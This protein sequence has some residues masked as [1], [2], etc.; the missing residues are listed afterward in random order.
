MRCWRAKGLFSAY[1]DNE[2]R[3]RELDAF[4]AHLDGCP[5]CRRELAELRVLKEAVGSVSYRLPAGFHEAVH[6]HSRLADLV[7]ERFRSRS[8][9][10]SARP[11]MRLVLVAASVVII[12]VGVGLL[13]LNN[14]TG[15]PSLKILDLPTVGDRVTE[16]SPTPAA[17]LEGERGEVAEA[18]AETVRKESGPETYLS[19][20]LAAAEVSQSSTEELSRHV[21]ADEALSRA[22]DIPVEISTGARFSLVSAGSPIPDDVAGLPSLPAGDAAE[23]DAEP[24]VEESIGE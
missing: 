20:H 14:L 23:A 5:D 1:M 13:G 17:E 4:S 15:A 8:E 7:T 3:G 21:L 18:V 22:A 9:A 6:S 12:A 19:E 16:S 11:N 10:R 24:P 2:L